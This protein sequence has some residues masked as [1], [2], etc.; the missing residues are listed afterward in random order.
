VDA[1]LTKIDVPRSLFSFLGWISLLQ[2]VTP[3]A[4][5]RETGL[6]PTTI[7]DYVRR[8]VERRDVRK[9][10]N[11]DDGRSYQ[12][13]LTAKG[14]EVANR[15]WP[16]VEKAFA[17]LQRGLERPASEHL[18]ALQEVRRAVQLAL[19]SQEAERNPTSRARHG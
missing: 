2:P 18:A 11:P 17:R 8:L 1:E 4:L 12:L 7:R 13:V 9:L 5:A 3:S 19:A 16:A 15:G 14:Q 6:P 10:P